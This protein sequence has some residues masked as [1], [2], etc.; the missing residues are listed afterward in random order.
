M[1]KHTKG[2]ISMT[3]AKNWAFTAPMS[4]CDVHT[5]IELL[6]KWCSFWVFGI[7]VGAD[8]YEH[9]QGH[10]TAKVGKELATL[11]NQFKDACDCI[12]FSKCA[13]V[14]GSI[15]YCKKT[16]NWISSEDGPIRRFAEM[17]LW[18]WQDKAEMYFQQQDDRRILVIVDEDGCKG[19]SAFG[20]Y[21]EAT[22]QADVCPVTDG[23]ASNYIEYCLNHPCTGY[24][25]DIPRA[26]SVK[27]KKAMW[28]AIEQIKNGCLYDRRY[29]SRKKWIEPP[30]IIVFANEEPPYDALSTD[31][32]VVCYIDTHWG[33]K[34]DAPLMPLQV[35]DQRA[36]SEI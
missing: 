4:R 30:K 34:E 14:A 15:A 26:D 6:D 8:G 9:F 29:T 7:E 12:H 28:R 20:K 25:F 11:R 27:T 2:G 23:D 1:P 10:L 21:L 5:L 22:H 36:M 18:E 13:D 31:R 33:S 32:W 17:E 35:G 24:V 19:K 3:D 16:G